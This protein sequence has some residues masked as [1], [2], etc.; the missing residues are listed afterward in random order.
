MQ[1]HVEVIQY[2]EYI[3]N[4]IFG[5]VLCNELP[6]ESVLPNTDHHP[7]EAVV[8][9]APDCEARQCSFTPTQT[10]WRV[11]A[12]RLVCDWDPSWLNIHNTVIHKS[13]WW[14]DQ[15]PL[16][17]FNDWKLKLHIHTSPGI[18]TK[19]KNHHF[20]LDSLWWLLFRNSVCVMDIMKSWQ[21]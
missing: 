20:K 4:Y 8:W 16:A 13:Y 19:T 15:F 1:F 9:S 6:F 17:L 10:R 3:T 14:M 18:H 5:H 2:S 11:N 7:A 21:Q 12:P